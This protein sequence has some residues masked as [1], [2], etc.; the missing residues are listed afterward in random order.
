MLQNNSKLHSI[1]GGD[2]LTAAW[3]GAAQEVKT[4]QLLPQRFDGLIPVIEDWHA[5]V[6]L[7][8]VCCFS[9]YFTPFHRLFWSTFITPVSLGTTAH[10]TSL[11]SDQ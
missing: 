6:V 3:I 8:E 7:L 4:I 2:Q 9:V 11:K 5:K 10:Y 1:F